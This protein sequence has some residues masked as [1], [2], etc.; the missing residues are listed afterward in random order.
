MVKAHNK[1]EINPL[2]GIVF[3]LINALAMSIIYVVA[4][5]LAKELHSSLIVFLYKFSILV[6]TIPWCMQNSFEGFKTNRLKL[7]AVRGFFS[8]AGSLSLYFAISHIDLADITAVGYIEQVILVIVGMLYF[9]EVVTPSKIIAIIISFLGVIL[10]VH[11][12]IAE[13]KILPIPEFL[14]DN[15]FSFNPYYIF[16]FMS[17]GF[18]ATNCIII[19]VLG[20]TEKSKVQLFYVMLFSSI[21]SFPLA[22]MKWRLEYEFL[23]LPIK[24]P[25]EFY[26]FAELGLKWD[27]LKYI[28]VLAACYFTH[29][30][31]FFK[32]LKYADLSTVIPFDYSRIIFTGIL[33]YLAFGESPEY[34]SLIGYA[35]IV[36]SGIYI[37]KAEAARKKRLKEMQV[38]QLEEEYEHA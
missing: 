4:K 29:S 3:M 9:K 5:D 33:G 6:I 21:Y 18:W 11:P 10:V 7:H 2:L 16:V 31:T 28:V 23:G 14:Q 22:F 24:M 27:H 32:S 36:F 38:K 34:G 25:Y 19:K 1:A 30:I 35:F 8:I 26:S 13:L 37:V 17:I 12:W 15:D 20:R